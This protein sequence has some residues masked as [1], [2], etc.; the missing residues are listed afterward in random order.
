MQV[1]YLVLRSGSPGRCWA[2]RPM[3]RRADV[4]GL[5]NLSIEELSNIE[6]TSG[7]KAR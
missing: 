7:I 6:I 5:K 1:R 2:R 3:G 4:Q